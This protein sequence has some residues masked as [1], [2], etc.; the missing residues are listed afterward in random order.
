M[1]WLDRLRNL[2]KRRE[3][4]SGLD[5]ELQFHIDARVRDNIAGGMSPSEA[6]QDAT[7]RFGNSTLAKERTRETDMFASIESTAKDVRYAFRSLCKSP[8]FTAT[9]ILVIALG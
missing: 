1:A 6:R 4:E 5:E 8:G 3:L 2:L 7:R 9:A